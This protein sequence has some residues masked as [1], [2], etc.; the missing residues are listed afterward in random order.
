M[1]VRN[2]VIDIGIDIGIFGKTLH[3]RRTRRLSKTHD[4]LADSLISGS[5]ST[6]G[7]PKVDPS[8]SEP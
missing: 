1:S 4:F 8:P 2:H 6:S 7:G 5:R 3:H